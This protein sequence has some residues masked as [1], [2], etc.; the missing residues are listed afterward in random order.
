MKI[1]GIESSCDET[2]AAVVEDGHRLLS[3][4]VAS[5]MD[6]HVQYGGVV[7]E[8]AARSH[9][10]V[11]LP[12]IAEALEAAGCTWDDIDGIAV[13]YGAGLSGSLLI[14]VMTAR[15]LAITHNK[16]LY[17][18]NHVE[19]HVYA[20]FLLEATF[21]ISSA[22]TKR[23]ADKTSNVA[24]LP[25]TPQTSATTSAS[26]PEGR[27]VSSGEGAEVVPLRSGQP[28]F[29]MLAIIVSGGHSQLALFQD[30]FDYELL[31]QTQDDAIGEAFD[32]VAKVLGLPYPGGPSVAKAALK[33]DP[34]A[35]KLPKA[36]MGKYDFSF[37]GLKTAVLRLAQAQIGERYDFPSFKLAERLSEAQKADIAASFQQ[38]AIETIVDK[39]LLAF[40]EYSPKSV[41][42]AGGV[43]ASPELRRQL[44]ERLPLP[45]EY[46]DMKLCTDNGAM[47]ATLGCFKAMREQ[48]AADPYT[49]AIQPNL[50]M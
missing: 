24:T 44:S 30:H 20:N 27:F 1:L 2:A 12:V 50:S 45:V 6:L 42:I 33:G 14:G 9:I 22:D 26:L 8:I 46:P 38:V 43:A 11:I 39:A 3:N 16:P 19:A 37:S 13:T 18:I 23:P 34:R 49:L 28:E 31:G 35:Y 7:P 25:P 32:K 40:E 29:P 4:V 41:V 48:P 5:S 36:K 47:V 21:D 10:E 17:A 15:T